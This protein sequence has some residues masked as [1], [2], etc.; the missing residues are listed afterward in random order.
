MV[1]ETWRRLYVGQAR[2]AINV[3]DVLERLLDNSAGVERHD[4]DR[5]DKSAGWSELGWILGEIVRRTD[6][7]RRAYRDFIQE[8]LCAPFGITDLWVGIPDH[9]E[10]RIAKLVVARSLLGR[11]CSP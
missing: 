9:V 6:P 3:V 5:A 2:L 7:K 10:P 11:A 8:E 4:P 1:S